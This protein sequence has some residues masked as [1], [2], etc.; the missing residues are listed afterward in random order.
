MR[1]NNSAISDQFIFYS[2]SASREQSLKIKT[3]IT[4][5][6]G[7]LNLGTSA[8]CKCTQKSKKHVC[9]QLVIYFQLYSPCF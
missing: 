4:V 6:L 5:Q 7:K 8:S 1:Q 2:T 9:T 3:T